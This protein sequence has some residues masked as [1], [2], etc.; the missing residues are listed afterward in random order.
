[1]LKVG[2]CEEVLDPKKEGAVFA[3]GL[4][5]GW[6]QPVGVVSGRGTSILC[7]TGRGCLPAGCSR[8]I[9]CLFFLQLLKSRFS[10]FFPQLVVSSCSPA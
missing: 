1:V 5:W 8:S 9:T 2:S 7:C 10:V 4:D 3:G 6:G